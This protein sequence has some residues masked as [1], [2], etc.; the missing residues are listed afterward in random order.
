MADI[1]TCPPLTRV[2]VVQAHDLIRPHVHLTPVLTN[3]TL[4]RLASTPR[5]RGSLEGTAWGGREPARP[6]VRLWFKCEN[7]QRVGAFKVRGAFHAVERLKGDREWVEGNHAQALAL[8]ARESGIPAH[9]VMPE[10][11]AAPKVAAT[12]GY[13]AHVVFSGS[14]SVE[15]EAMAA[16]VMAETG[17]TLVPPY[18]HP[19][20]MLG[21]G[22]L[23]LEFQEQVE[24]LMR[25]AAAEAPCGGGGMLSGVALSCEG[26]GITV[27]GA[28]PSFEGADD[29]QRGF[30]TGERVEKVSTLTVADGLRT[31]VGEFPW[32]VIYERRLVREMF[33][34]TEDE[35]RA[36]LRLVLERMKMVVEPSAAVP[37]A[38]VLFNEDFRSLVEREA[39][40]EGWDIGVVLSGGN[41][42]MTVPSDDDAATT[43]SI[44]STEHDIIDISKAP[45]VVSWIGEDGQPRSLCHSPLDHSHVTLD[46]QFNAESHTA[47]FK[48]TANIAFKGKRNKSNTFLFVYPE[49]VQSL[50]VVDEDDGSVFAQN[51]LGTNTYSLRFTLATPC[52]LVVPRD[53]LVP[54]DNAARATLESLQDLAGKTSFQV[55]FP[56]KILPKDRLV[57]LCD[58]ASSSGRLKT[59]PGVENLAKLYGGKG[60]RV[61]EYKQA[62]TSEVLSTEEL[63]DTQPWVASPGPDDRGRGDS[64]NSKTRPHDTVESPPSYDEL[65]LGHSPS[66]RPP[67]KKRR[68]LDSEVMARD[69]SQSKTLLEEICRQGFGEI[70]RRLDRIEQRLDDMGNRLDRVEQRICIG[71]GQEDLSS[72]QRPTK[73]DNRQRDELGQRIECVEERIASV[74]EKLETGLSELADTIEDQMADAKNDLE[75]SVLVYVE[76]EMGIAQSQFEDFVKSEVRNVGEDI[77]E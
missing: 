36:A 51:R 19:D 52:A 23:G 37:L 55:N 70:G 17:A 45:A 56:C 54:K 75:H 7:M 71:N 15:R 65:D 29:C 50:A 11:S 31:P 67:V 47:V 21:Q 73:Q 39:G 9:I 16:K 4:T 53:E 63:V 77:E 66:T 33:S 10:I 30:E 28:E 68:R 32:A 62:E 34:V 57:A 26:T 18:D 1:S 14:T 5:S 2:S 27:F 8:A 13:G 42:P 12:K 41:V 69:T 58:E 35:I 38:V 74:E 20:I 3:A 72:G 25:S 44:D 24:G 43:A 76:D 46:I 48:L 6:V 22:T 49:R 60:G 64:Q 61:I 40:E 59:M